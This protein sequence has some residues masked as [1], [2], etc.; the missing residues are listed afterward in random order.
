MNP[1]DFEFTDDDLEAW[2]SGHGP[3]V[4]SDLT[5]LIVDLRR[6]VESFTEE[7][8]PKLA[9]WIAHSSRCRKS[10]APSRAHV[11]ELD[12]IIESLAHLR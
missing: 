3:A 8:S 4:D 2:L 7:P 12:D 1:E 10:D 11:A 5:R 6:E 9:S